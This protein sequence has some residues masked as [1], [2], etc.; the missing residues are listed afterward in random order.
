MCYKPNWSKEVLMIEKIED[1][2]PSAYT[3]EELNRM[4]SLELFMNKN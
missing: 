2:L 3:I 4:E 1:T